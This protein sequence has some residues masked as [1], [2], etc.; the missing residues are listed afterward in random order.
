MSYPRILSP[1]TRVYWAGWEGHTLALQQAGWEI[2]AEQNYCNMGYRFAFK[3]PV[4][5]MYGISHPVDEFAIRS[6]YQSPHLSP[7]PPIQLAHI[8]SDLRVYIHDNLDCFK[9]I[10]AAPS[11]CMDE[12]RNIEDFKIFRTI[13]KCR[14]TVIEKHTVPELLELILKYQSPRQ[15][16]LRE[17]KRR[18]YRKFQREVNALSEDFMNEY[19]PRNDIVAQ[20]VTV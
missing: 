16:E 17:K 8:A 4:L 13:A 3:H 6:H 11:V 15:K 18:E 1:N 14:D 7:F 12:I 2:S 10:D 5:K 19:D 20:I 9:P